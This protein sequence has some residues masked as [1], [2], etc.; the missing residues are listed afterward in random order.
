VWCSYIGVVVSSRESVIGFE[1]VVSEFDFLPVGGF[2]PVPFFES[3]W[4]GDIVGY[5]IR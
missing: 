3:D 2:S 4:D 5:W 1:S